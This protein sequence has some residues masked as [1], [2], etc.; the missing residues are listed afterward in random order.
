[1]EECITYCKA[2]PGEGGCNQLRE[3]YEKGLHPENQGQRPRS[4][5]EAKDL[6]RVFSGGNCQGTGN[7]NFTHSPMNDEDISFIQPLGLMVGEHVT[8]IDHLYLNPIDIN[9]PRD[10]YGVYAIANATIVS[11]QHRLQDAYSGRPFTDEYRLVF[12][13]SCTLY[14]YYD[15]LTS[16]SPG[17]L[18]QVQFQGLYS[19]TR[20]R[21]TAGELIGKIGGQTL[22]FSVFNQGVN[23]TGFVNQAS[24]DSE[25]WK[26][27]VDNPFPYFVEPIRS[28]LLSK[29]LRTSPPRW[30]KIDYDIDGRLAGNWFLNAT[31]GYGA[32]G[33][34]HPSRGHLSLSYDY[35][36]PTQVRVSLGDFP[37]IGSTQF[38]VAGNAPDPATISTSSGLV[39]Y[40]LVQFA[41]H[42]ADGQQ[43]NDHTAFA[44]GITAKGID[45]QPQGTAL[46]QLLD[47]R[48]LK[49]EFFKQTGVT[50]FDE[51]AKIYVR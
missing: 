4:Q 1:M 5:M 12:E 26:I 35:L 18:S 19:N 2:N 45:N 14:S 38:G 48:T 9:S 6:N 41:Y 30:G 47:N 50:N 22:D 23:L 31:K 42:G 39:K 51:N 37:G 8:P 17:I 32:L 28:T 40:T 36:D 3:R 16:L 7:V 11:I 49:A 44:S 13:H 33:A 10:A 34:N 15:L 25:P 21:V 29:L 24:Y 46:L 27:H 20:L 43:W